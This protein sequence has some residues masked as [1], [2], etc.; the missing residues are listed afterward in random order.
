MQRNTAGA[1]PLPSRP[2]NRRLCVGSLPLALLVTI[3][4]LLKGP[5]RGRPPARPCFPISPAG[6]RPATRPLAD[7]STPRTQ[8]E[9]ANTALLLSVALRPHLQT[10]AIEI[11]TLRPAMVSTLVRIDRKFCPLAR[12][13]PRKRGALTHAMDM[14]MGMAPRWFLAMTVDLVSQLDRN[15]HRPAIAN[16]TFGD[17]LVGTSLHRRRPAFQQ[18]YFH[19]ALMVEMQMQSRVR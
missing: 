18:G 6:I 16:T 4:K 7:R 1:Q 3:G 17:H 13:Q 2:A 11:R 15:D 9:R 14:G 8:R 5:L 12:Q 10:R 19:T